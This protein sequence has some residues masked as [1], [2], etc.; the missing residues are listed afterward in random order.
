MPESDQLC[1]LGEPLRPERRGNAVAGQAAVALGWSG[2]V[3]AGMRLFGHDVAVVAEVDQQA[4]EQRLGTGWGPVTDRMSVALWEWP[5]HRATVPPSAVALRGVIAQG[6]RWQRVLASAVGFI[7]FCSTAIVLE[8]A[9]D[10]GQH[11]L[12]TAHLYGV[13]VVRLGPPEGG[14]SLVQEGRDGPVETA[15][16]STL[17]RWVEELV[18]SRLLEDHMIRTS[19]AG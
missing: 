8:H 13:S 17:T 4:H 18:Y 16:P 19:T 15:R 2:A 10:P 5:E 3:A 11:C 12:L 14:P 7:G 6:Q 1:L 9:H